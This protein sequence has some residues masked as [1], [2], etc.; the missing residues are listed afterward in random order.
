MVEFINFDIHSESFTTFL[1]NHVIQQQQ[2]GQIPVIIGL[3]L[4]GMLSY[5]VITL[6]NTIPEIPILIISP[7]CMPPRSKKNN[8][9]NKVD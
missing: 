1:T 8:A 9:E 4:C 6:F 2:S 7:C 3:H 5:R